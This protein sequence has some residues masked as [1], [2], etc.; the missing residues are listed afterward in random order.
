MSQALRTLADVSRSF[1]QAYRAAIEE[2]IKLRLPLTTC[3]IYNGCM[4]DAEL[5]QQ[6]TAGLTIFNDA[7]LRTA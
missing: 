2:C 5:Q 7:I 4:A 3:M 6:V 1:E